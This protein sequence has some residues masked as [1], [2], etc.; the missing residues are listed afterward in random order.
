MRGAGICVSESDAER[1]LKASL[2]GLPF[3]PAGFLAYDAEVGVDDVDG[4]DGVDGV[5]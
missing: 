3:V 5:A 2:G 1:P 4:V